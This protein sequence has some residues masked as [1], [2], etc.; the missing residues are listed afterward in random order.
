MLAHLQEHRDAGHSVPQSCVDD[1]IVDQ[2]ENDRWIANFNP[3]EE[4]R[5]NAEANQRIHDIW[6]VA[7]EE[8]G[9]VHPGPEKFDWEAHHD[10]WERA[11][12]IYEQRAQLATSVMPPIPQEKTP[13]VKSASGHRGA[14]LRVQQ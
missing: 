8:L 12:L 2:E 6:Q 1:L 7:K 11:R 3:V 13:P 5:K 14:G 9:Y 4:Q 10:A